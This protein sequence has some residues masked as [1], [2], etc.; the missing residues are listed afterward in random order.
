MLL[1]LFPSTDPTAFF[2]IVTSTVVVDTFFGN[3]PENLYIKNN[4]FIVTNKYTQY[5]GKIIIINYVIMLVLLF[6][7]NYTRSK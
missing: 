7:N 6:D 4:I 1:P 3:P 2:G 5:I